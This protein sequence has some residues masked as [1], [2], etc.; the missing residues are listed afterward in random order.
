MAG[1]PMLAAGS[2]AGSGAAGPPARASGPGLSAVLTAMRGPQ[3][4]VLNPGPPTG[5]TATAG[6]AQ[7]TL[8][9]T[10]PASD[11]GTAISG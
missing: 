7:V 3:A 2:T 8:S 10:P 5:L 4:R 11:G 1:W 9:W 6:N